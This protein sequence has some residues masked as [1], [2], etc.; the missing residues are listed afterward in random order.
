[1]WGYAKSSQ[2]RLVRRTCA[3]A[4]R[5]HR[6]ARAAADECPGAVR[7]RHAHPGRDRRAHPTPEPDNGLPKVNTGSWEL[8]LVNAQNSIGE[9]VPED[10]A[11][12]ESGRYFDAC[13][14]DALKDFIAG[15]RAEG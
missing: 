15:A 11:E 2:N 3:G 13:A 4:G 1:M 12:L 7:R 10:L 6:A 8:T 9:A 14:V 5:G